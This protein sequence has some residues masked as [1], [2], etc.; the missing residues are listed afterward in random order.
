MSPTP[1]WIFEPY[2]VDPANACVWRGDQMIPLRPKVF[3][4][5]A[6]LV[7]RAGQLV[8]N[9]ALFEAV[10]PET[11]ITDAV[12]KAGIREVRR[13]LGDTAQTPQFIATVHRRGYRFIAPVTVE[14]STAV[15]QPMADSGRQWPRNRQQ[16]LTTATSPRC[17]SIVEREDVLQQL[18]IGLE[19]ARQGRRQVIF[20]TGEPGISKTAVI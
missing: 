4:V 3:A 9:E 16:K 14:T 12:L 19:E 2:R 10:W 18:H 6:H 5:L 1:Q 11:A 8:T 15:G 7:A 17:S 20:L 13:A